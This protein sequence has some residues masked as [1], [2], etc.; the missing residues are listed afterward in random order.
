MDVAGRNDNQVIWYE[1]NGDQISAV[2]DFDN[3]RMKYTYTDGRLTKVKD[4]L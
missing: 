3:S 4:V 2:R 1:H